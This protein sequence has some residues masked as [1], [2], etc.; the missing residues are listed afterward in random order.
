VVDVSLLATSMMFMNPL[1]LERN[2]TGTVRRRIGNTSFYTA[3][4]DAYQARDGWILVPT[5]GQAMF[6]RWAR[7][8]GR[9][10]LL[11]DPRCADDQARADHAELINGVMRAWCGERTRAEALAE[12]ERARIPAGPVYALDEAIADS[13]VVARRLLEPHDAPDKSRPLPLAAPPT[14][15][16]ATPARIR[17]GPP[18]LGQ[19]TAEILGELGFTADEIAA[20]RAAE[21]V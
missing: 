4:S 16:S 18:A 10:D 17:R 15:L 9:E 13:H 3:P 5:A 2:V 6:R 19:H 12:L 7:L 1:L 20:F 21:I 14:H 11:S 8:V